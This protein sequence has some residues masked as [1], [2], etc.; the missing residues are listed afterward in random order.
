MLPPK[1]PTEATEALGPPIEMSFPSL[2]SSCWL[3]QRGGHRRS[4]R[5]DSRSNGL[6]AA[7]SLFSH[8][9]LFLRRKIVPLC[10]AERS[11][12]CFLLVSAVCLAAFLVIRC[13]PSGCDEA[14]LFEQNPALET[15][16]NV[17][18]ALDERVRIAGVPTLR[19][20]AGSRCNPNLNHSV[21]HAISTSEVIDDRLEAP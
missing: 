8:V 10:N 13:V 9:S 15:S 1:R 19:D 17:S 12:F 7:W 16:A 18:C 6:V 20:A 14:L 4:I 21:A 11:L 2:P 5:V 3:Y